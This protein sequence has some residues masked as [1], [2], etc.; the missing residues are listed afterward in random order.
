[1]KLLPSRRKFCV[2]LTAMLH[3]TSCK[4]TYVRCMLFVVVVGGGGGG[5]GVV[6]VV[7]ASACERS[8]IKM[9]SIEITFIIIGPKTIL[10]ARVYVRFSS[11]E[12]LHAAALKV[13]KPSRIIPACE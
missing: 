12:I 9:Q 10:F 2:H 6:V 1:M 4:A 5:G 7:F 8:C 13:L 11:P 3:V